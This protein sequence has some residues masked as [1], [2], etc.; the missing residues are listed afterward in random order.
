MNTTIQD[1]I[2]REITVRAP[3]ERVYKAITEPEQITKWFPDAIEGTL[4]AGDSPSIE[5]TG[6][7]KYQILVTAADP[8]DYFAYRW[9]SSLPGTT[10]FQGDVLAHPNTLVEFRLS[11]NEG[12]TTVK[13]KESGFASLPPE[14][15]EKSRSDNSEG[16]TEMMGRLEKYIGGE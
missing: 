11:E 9:V 8:Y 10:G 2:E 13:L 7:G 5:F 6:Y 14:F 15:M 4:G 3:K 16:W 12:A 1:T